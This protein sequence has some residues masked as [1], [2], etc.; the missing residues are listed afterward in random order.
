MEVENKNSKFSDPKKDL[1]VKYEKEFYDLK[2]F[3]H[4]HPGGINILQDKNSKSIDMSFNAANHSLAAK[5][6]LNE[7]KLR[8]LDTENKE[9]LEVKMLFK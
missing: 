2:S 6:L 5:Y 9:G 8:S 4:K 3:I 1:I 7:Y